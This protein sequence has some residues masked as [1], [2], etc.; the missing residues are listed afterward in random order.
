M[1]QVQE[2]VDVD[3]PIRVA[4]NQWTQFESF[5]H[6][7]AGR[8]HHP[9]R[10]HPQPLG[11]QDRWGD[12]GV[13]H[14]DHRAAPRRESGLDQCGRR[15]PAR[16]RGHLPPAR[17]RQDPGHGPAGLGALGF[18][19]K[20]RQC[21]GVDDHQIKADT[22]RSRSTSKAMAPPPVDG[23]ATSATPRPVRAISGRDR[24]DAGEGPDR[25]QFS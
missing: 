11:H 10:R 16:R 7:M 6:F 5:P 21:V 22:K 19:R 1:S 25:G 24:A 12:P 17:G 13:R 20:A 2:S 4:Y 23:G 9:D 3:V 15:H 18:G 14:R 8:V